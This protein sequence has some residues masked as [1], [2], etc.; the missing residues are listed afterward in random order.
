MDRQGN[1]DPG[2]DESA[3]ASWEVGGGSEAGAEVTGVTRGSEPE[4]EGV[5]GGVLAGVTAGPVGG[6]SKAQAERVVAEASSKAGGGSVAGA[7]VEGSSASFVA[8]GMGVPLVLT[9]AEMAAQGFDIGVDIVLATMEEEE[10]V[11]PDAEAE[12]DAMMLATDNLRF[13][14]NSRQPVNENEVNVDPVA[15]AEFDAMILAANNFR[16]AQQ[17]R[18][19]PSADTFQPENE[20]EDER[21]PTNQP[22]PEN[23]TLYGSSISQQ[24]QNDTL[25]GSSIPQGGDSNTLHGSS[26]P[27]GG[28]NDPGS[29]TWFKLKV[30]SAF[31]GHGHVAA[32]RGR[33]CRGR[34]EP[35]GLHRAATG[36]M[37]LGAALCWGAAAPSGPHPSPASSSPSTSPLTAAM[38][39]S[40]HQVPLP[41]YFG[42]FEAVLTFVDAQAIS[43]MS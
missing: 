14:Q 36:P 5:R 6:G 10:D 1:G 13:A 40:P 35:R 37:P 29:A 21:V 15:E 19:V 42:F 28:D 27:Q 4:A 26:I 18:Q 2:N 11:D 3:T 16:F 39:R 23:D 31:Q 34:A 8:E 12:F 20:N 41:L 25:H 7:E 32:G 38:C 17:M 9:A 22:N 43:S 30:P 24:I 33:P